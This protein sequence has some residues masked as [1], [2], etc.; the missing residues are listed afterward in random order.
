L[1][2]AGV[3][4]SQLI[5]RSTTPIGCGRLHMCRVPCRASGSI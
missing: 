3:A 2:I 4:A 1:A 5:S